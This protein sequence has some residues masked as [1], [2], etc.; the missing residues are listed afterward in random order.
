MR[1]KLVSF[2]ML[3]GIVA[4]LT[5]SAQHS[6]KLAACRDRREGLRDALADLHGMAGAAASEMI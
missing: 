4:P 6:P 3:C 5:V 2:M 1:R